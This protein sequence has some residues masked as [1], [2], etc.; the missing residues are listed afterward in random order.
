[1]C[2]FR[3]ITKEKGRSEV[4]KISQKQ[5]GLF[6]T[7]IKCFHTFE[8]LFWTLKIGQGLSNNT[9]LIEALKTLYEGPI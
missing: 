1:M 7:H 6:E 8:Y 2:N 5:T 9:E 3:G 4:Q